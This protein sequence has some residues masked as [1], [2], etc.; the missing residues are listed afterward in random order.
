LVPTYNERKIYSDRYKTVQTA[1]FPGYIFCRFDSDHKS[2]I[3]SSPAV[4]CIVSFGGEPAI[5]SDGDIEAVRRTVEAG[6]Q[7]CEY[8]PVG[9]QIRITSGVLAGLEG[10]LLSAGKQNRLVVSIHLL[11][12]SVAVKIGRE[13]LKPL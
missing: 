3:L 11:Q 5:I 4:Q 6:G 7:P 8:I 10:V 13:C 1:V 9:Q 12:R 2:P